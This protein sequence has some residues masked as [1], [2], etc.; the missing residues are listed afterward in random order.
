MKKMNKTSI[1]ILIITVMTN[2]NILP[3]QDLLRTQ[4]IP[5][6]IRFDSEGRFPKSQWSL[7]VFWR[8]WLTGSSR[9]GG[10]LN[11]NL[12]GGKSSN[13][14]TAGFASNIIFNITQNIGLVS[15]LEIAVYSGK[16][17]GNFE[18][19]YDTWNSKDG[20][21]TFNYILRDYSEQQ[22]LALLSIPLMVRYSTNP[23]SDVYAKYF[24]AF[25]FK[26]GIP[27]VRRAVIQPGVLTTTAYLHEDKILYD[28]FPE[29][30]LVTNFHA[31][32]QRSKMD[33][34]VG[35]ALSL[36]T[37]V[38]VM[39]NEKISAGASIYC[40]F[41][42]NK[43]LRPGNMHIVEYQESKPGKLLFNSIMTTNRVS[44][45]EQFSVGIKLTVYFNPD[46]AN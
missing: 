15:G 4:K 21:L 23:F 18:E 36:E 17:T 6:D 22:K 39:S 14:Y 9:W 33:F 26:I 20:D 11:Y 7:S 2:I 42:L 41:G 1:I 16:A 5:D 28:G 46:K 25:G 34:N 10:G 31:P 32:V 19:S 3:A 8:G 30:G 12:D 29:Q 27:L 43:L 40:D 35:A 44:S 37:G 38:T 45:I 13:V 24:A